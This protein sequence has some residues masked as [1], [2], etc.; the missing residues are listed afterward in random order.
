[1]KMPSAIA[2][3]ATQIKK[4]FIISSQ[5]PK[6]NLFFFSFIWLLQNWWFWI[7]SW[8]RKNLWLSVFT[9][10]NNKHLKILLTK[11][12]SLIHILYCLCPNSENPNFDI[13]LHFPRRLDPLRNLVIFSTLLQQHVTNNRI[14]NNHHRIQISNQQRLQNQGPTGRGRR[15]SIISSDDAVLK[16]SFNGGQGH[17]HGHSE[18]QCSGGP[19]P[20]RHAR[21]ENRGEAAAAVGGRHDHG[22]AAD[23]V[24][25]GKND[26]VDYGASCREEQ[27]ES[28]RREAQHVGAVEGGGEEGEGG[29]VGGEDEEWAADLSDEE[30]VEGCDPRKECVVLIGFV[31]VVVEEC[32]D[33]GLS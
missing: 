20:D 22:Q 18:R 33:G 17:V 26:G 23:D 13:I 10:S 4:F 8:S 1:M 6:T 15:G 31:I 16:Q 2:I 28:R 5:R 19:A 32:D 30:A 25:I 24:G 21:L 11:T 12:K 3:N 29:G 14:K 27:P 7:Q 9:F